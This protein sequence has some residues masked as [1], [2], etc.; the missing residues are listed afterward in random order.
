MGLYITAPGGGVGV[1]RA[2]EVEHRPAS[3][4]LQNVG[5]CNAPLGAQTWHDVH[6]L[7]PDALEGWTPLAAL[8]LH[9][10]NFHRSEVLEVLPIEE[11]IFVVV[12]EL[13][14]LCEARIRRTGICH[15]DAKPGRVNQRITWVLW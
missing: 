12:E 10:R 13:D 2:E 7:Q 6:K 5:R 4:L 3:A 9:L 11:A 14:P 8:S 15:E 1:G